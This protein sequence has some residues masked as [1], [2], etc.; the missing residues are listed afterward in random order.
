MTEQENNNTKPV[1]ISN[2]DNQKEEIIESKKEEIKE[3]NNEEEM[4]EEMEEQNEQNENE[5]INEQEIGEEMIE[6]PND[7]QNIEEEMVE[8]ENN[9]NQI[10]ENE[11][12][13]NQ[14]ED[15][16]ENEQNND[17]EM[18]ENNDNNDNNLA[19]SNNEDN[20][21]NNNINNIEKENEKDEI[22]NNEN[23]SRV[24]NENNNDLGNSNSN[25]I[26]SYINNNI[27]NSN[28][29]YYSYQP[30][31]Y[32]SL[33]NKKDLGLEDRKI[34]EKYNNDDYKKRLTYDY[35]YDYSNPKYKKYPSSNNY[36]YNSLCDYTSKTNYILNNDYSKPITYFER[37]NL[38]TKG[39]AKDLPLFENRAYQRP[40]NITYTYCIQQSKDKYDYGLK[41]NFPENILHNTKFES[42]HI[43]S[44]PTDYKYQR[45]FKND[46]D[47]NN[48]NSNIENSIIKKDISTNN[49]INNKKVEN[50]Q[51]SESENNNNINFNKIIKEKNNIKEE[52][53]IESIPKQN[54]YHFKITPNSNYNNNINYNNNKKEY[55][56]IKNEIIINRSPSDIYYNTLHEEY[57]PQKEDNQFNTNKS[58]YRTYEIDSS[59]YSDNNNSLFGHSMIYNDL[60]RKNLNYY[61]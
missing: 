39:Y 3:S 32:N 8:E 11:M 22:N 59:K 43:P 42:Y 23:Q 61:Y 37:N 46:K 49:N 50:N 12:I 1:E 54:L 55:N 9:I 17:N 52:N 56:N 28:N 21:V 20:D 26:P 25:N 6:N 41:K 24:K 31:K 53:N 34:L 38:D 29:N 36:K 18:I 4:I 35:F 27:N 19:Q 40:K 14:E 2:V 15:N 58:I 60:K 45:Y 47:N 33:L 44:S 10:N 51:L 30:S 16:I 13:E 48:L 57:L 5:Q 7:E